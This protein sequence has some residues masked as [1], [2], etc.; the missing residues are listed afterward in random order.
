VGPPTQGLGFAQAACI[1]YFLLQP[2]FCVGRDH[3]QP[4]DQAALDRYTSGRL[5]AH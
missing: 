5:I 1:L 3:S 4:L 2:S